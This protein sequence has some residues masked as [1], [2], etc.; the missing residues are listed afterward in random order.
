MLRQFCPKANFDINAYTE[1]AKE[2]EN[3]FETFVELCVEIP[4]ANSKYGL[5]KSSVPSVTYGCVIV[6]DSAKPIQ[7]KLLQ[8]YE[9]W[10]AVTKLIAKQYSDRYELFEEEYP[11]IKGCILGNY[12]SKKILRNRFIAAFDEQVN[13]LHTIIPTIS[14]K[15]TNFKKILT[16][17]LLNSE[18]EQAEILYKYN[19]NR[20]SG[21]I[22]GVVLERYLKTLCE[23][24]LID[25]GEKD[26]IEPLATKLYKSDEVP[27]FDLTLFKSIQHLSSIRNNCTHSKEDVKSHD[28]RELLDKV[29]KITFLAL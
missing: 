11:A 4:A 14:L 19:L 10:F 8:K 29:K 25:V 22:A 9:I 2:L 27:D 21:A 20:A 1:E 23:V 24:N 28:V 17:D 15:E 26:T 18:L 12:V 5:V 6:S 13:I 7:R 16:T 3:L